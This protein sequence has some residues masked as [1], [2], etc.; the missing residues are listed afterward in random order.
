[1]APSLFGPHQ[2]MMGEVLFQL[3]QAFQSCTNPC[4]VYP[5]T[6]YVIDEFNVFRPDIAV[7]CR[8]VT[9][10]IEAAPLMIVEILSE[11]TALIDTTVK[12]QTYEKEGVKHYMMIDYARRR[13]KLYGLQTNGYMLAADKK[14]GKFEVAL[15]EGCRIVFDIDAW[16]EMI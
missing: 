6:D 16:W 9:R 5:E 12:F 13:V 11:S 1:M 10:H 15:D 7:V 4:Y 8:K 14:T 2:A 3:R